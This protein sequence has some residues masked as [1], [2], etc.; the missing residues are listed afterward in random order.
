[1]PISLAWRCQ[2]AKRQR[3]NLARQK[4][5]I[6]VTPEPA[7]SLETPA[8]IEEQLSAQEKSA[9]QLAISLARAGT[10]CRLCSYEHRGS[11]KQ[12]SARKKCRPAMR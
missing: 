1:M 8:K 9:A 7:Q 11:T 10:R 12:R 4:K 6:P 3:L 5:P 2:Q